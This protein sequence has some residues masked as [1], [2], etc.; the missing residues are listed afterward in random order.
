M[1]I[2][3]INSKLQQYS[4]DSVNKGAN[5]DFAGVFRIAAYESGKRC[6]YQALA[7]DGI[8]EY[9]GVTFVCDFEHNQITLGDVSN[10]K[11]CITVALSEGGSLVVNRDNL[12]DL[13]KAVGMFSPEDVNRILR[14]ITLDNKVRQMQQELDDEEDG[15]IKIGA[16]K[17]N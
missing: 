11:D 12:S 4:S 10:K 3:G 6:P 5:G 2:S 8:I 1:D 14:A 16:E 15:V 9:N 13:S 17:E 7:K